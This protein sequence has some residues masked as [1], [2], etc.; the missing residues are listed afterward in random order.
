MFN[1]IWTCIIWTCKKNK[2][3]HRRLT[4]LEHFPFKKMEFAFTFLLERNVLS[5]PDMF[6]RQPNPQNV[7]KTF[8]NAH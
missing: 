4:Q 3:K 2:A 8:E 5:S 7:V 1:L 6:H